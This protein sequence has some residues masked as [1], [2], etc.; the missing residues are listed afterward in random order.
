VCVCA[1]VCVYAFVWVR[2]YVCTCMRVCV[3]VLMSVGV[4]SSRTH[5][6]HLAG[7]LAPHPRVSTYS[8]CT[9]YRSL[10]QSIVSFIGLFC[11][12]DL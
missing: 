3:C 12:R 10:L 6:I 9:N 4:A 5:G 8:I 11:K 2:V 1:C 7:A